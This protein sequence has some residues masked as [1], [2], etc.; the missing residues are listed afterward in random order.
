MIDDDISKYSQLLV[1]G[2]HLDVQTDGQIC[3]VLMEIMDTIANGVHQSHL[4]LGLVFLSI[5]YRYNILGLFVNIDI[6]IDILAVLVTDTLPIID[7][8]R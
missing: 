2:L 8:C 5:Q 6:D 1:S 7:F 4:G 3:T